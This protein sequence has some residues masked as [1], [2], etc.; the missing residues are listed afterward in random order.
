MD[1]LDFPLSRLCYAAHTEDVVEFQRAGFAAWLARQLDPKA[2]SDADLDSRLRAFK[3]QIKYGSGNG[4]T[5]PKGDARNWPAM[6]EMRPLTY[7][8]A[9]IETT[10]AL[11]IPKSRGPWKNRRGLITRC[12]G[13]DR[14]ARRPQ[15]SPALRAG[16]SLLARPLQRSRQ[17][18]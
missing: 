4:E 1:V 15:P 11:S 10:W 2:L 13:S 6:D 12:G 8:D 18:R 9:P 3:L 16:R 14:S 5:T 17:R 7:L